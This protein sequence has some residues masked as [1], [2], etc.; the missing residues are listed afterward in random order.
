MLFSLQLSQML[1]VWEI[2]LMIN[3][4]CIGNVDDQLKQT[5]HEELAYIKMYHPD[6]KVSELGK[7]ASLI[8]SRLF[9]GMHHLSQPQI[10]KIDWSDEHFIQYTHNRSMSTTDPDDLTHLVLLAHEYG[11]RVTIDS[12]SFNYF[13]IIFHPRK[14]R[15]GRFDERHPTIHQVIK[16][17]E[18]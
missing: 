8:L 16:R 7:R 6:M 4:E 9:G 12:C 17:F 10:K 18:Y 14:N 1:F 5:N 13:H 3:G 15:D 2:E 11:I